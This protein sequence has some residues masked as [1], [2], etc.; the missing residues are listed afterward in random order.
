MRANPITILVGAAA[1]ALLAS[2][3]S[4]SQHTIHQPYDVETFGEFRQLMMAGDFTAKVGLNAAM[5]RHPTTGVGALADARG[6]I[7]IFDGKLIVSHGKTGVAEDANSESA[8][9]LAMG[10]VAEWQSVRVEQDVAPE[11]IESTIVVAAKAHG[12]DPEVAFPFE[13]QGSIGPYVM[14]VNAAPIDGEHGMG[15]PMAVTVQSKGDRL[16]GMVAGLYASLDL[17]GV[18]THGGERT[19][20]HWI[21]SD[22]A[23]TAHLDRWGLKAG[24]ILL[25]PKPVQ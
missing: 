24:A 15:L 10:S 14:H 13:V 9:L 7:T 22:L 23:S 19:H 5:A 25:L 11:E 6:E 21:S 2:E 3:P 17:M 8:A 16:D 4:L 12:I 1:L 20:A 18:A